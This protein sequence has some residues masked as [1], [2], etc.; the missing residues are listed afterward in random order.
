MDAYLI[1][2]PDSRNITIPE[3]ESAF[4]VYGDNN[5]ERKYFKSPRIVG[6][7]IDLTECY[8][9]VN[10]ISAS[11]KIGQ[12]LCDVG[13]A[14]NGTAT[15]DE[16][17]FSWPIT[18]NVLDKNISGE[19]FFAVQAKTKTGDTVFTTRKAKG[20]C[21]ESIEGTEAVAEEYADIVLQLISRMDKVEENIGEQVAAYFKEN[22]AV[23]SEYLTQ[24]LQPIK[25]D[26]GSIKEDLGNLSDK[27]ELEY[28]QCLMSASGLNYAALEKTGNQLVAGVKY[29]IKF[30]PTD[31]FDLTDVKMGTDGTAS[32]MV[33]LISAEL[34]FVS[35]IET[36]VEYTPTVSNLTYIRLVSHAK[37]FD[38]IVF[39]TTSLS[40]KG[41]SEL[42]ENAENNKKRIEEVVIDSR[43][44]LERLSAIS[45]ISLNEYE[46]QSTKNSIEKFNA[47]SN[48]KVSDSEM[49][50]FHVPNDGSDNLKNQ[51]ICVHLHNAEQSLKNSRWNEIYSPRFGK[52][53]NGIKFFD[54]YNALP[55]KVVA[56]ANMDVEWDDKIS[57]GQQSP[58]VTSDGKIIIANNGVSI[59]DDG[60]TW[61]KICEDNSDTKELCFVDSNDNLYLVANYKLCK[62]I[63]PYKSGKV[64]LD[65]SSEKRGFG[66]MAEDSLGNLYFGAYQAA[67]IGAVVYKSSDG[68]NNWNECLRDSVR[69]HIHSININKNKTPNEIFVG[70]DDAKHPTGACCMMSTDYGENWVELPI[71]FS[72]REYACRLCGENYYLGVGESNILGGVTMY[73][74]NDVMN[75]NDYEIVVNNKQ[76]ARRFAI[77]DDETIYCFLVAG[78]TVLTQQIIKSND[79]GRTWKTVW[80]D[81]TD[82]NG[83][84]GNGFRYVAK[85]KDKFWLSGYGN[86]MSAYLHHG[87]NHYMS[88]VLV[89]I[90]DI[91]VG[92]KDISIS[93][94][95]VCNRDD[96]FSVCV[97]G[98]V[99][100]IEFNED[101]ITDFMSNKKVYCEMDSDYTAKRNHN[102][103]VPSD[104]YRSIVGKPK[105]PVNMGKMKHLCSNKGITIEFWLDN[106]CDNSQMNDGKDYCLFSIGSFNIV[107]RSNQVQFKYGD[108]INGFVGFDAR[109]NNLTDYNHYCI[110]I[111]ADELPKLTPFT[112]DYKGTERQ[113]TSWDIVNMSDFDMIIG[114]T[115]NAQPF[116]YY[117]SKLKIYSRILTRDEIMKS[118]GDGLVSNVK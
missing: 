12:I 25:D 56:S 53:F 21:Y 63:K 24:T 102:I 61:T 81:S 85:Y 113:A 118:W 117:I 37:D 79:A 48:V 83:V 77:S 50:S 103:L 94:D 91:P 23:T 96:D 75:P 90:G 99:C 88:T 105:K 73:R 36:V 98:L 17:V 16:I 5:A 84:A 7:G 38:S 34:S 15:E 93:L 86:N 22:P 108:R 92:G 87:G 3:I 55:Y 58:L 49:I 67:W 76:S 82:M 70:I 29:I 101:S 72:N 40:P 9:Y 112:Y 19:I 68:G 6:N 106:K 52:E 18:R 13:D 42:V 11:T 43:I 41:Y 1:V 115:K 95:Y 60:V 69:Q 74:C 116:P 33:D 54:E 32:A 62:Y 104:V 65:M 10:Y 114:D 111:S 97:D 47:M 71:P 2:D 57:F 109:T 64:V 27:N 66:D 110:T 78:G 8:L 89:K 80:V 39:Y 45:D 35:G 107:M 46:T 31:T 44:S 4:G 59:S 51:T 26:V 30:L 20:N 100:D 28:C 14:P